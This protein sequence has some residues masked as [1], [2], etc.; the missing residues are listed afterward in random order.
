MPSAGK[1]GTGLT[2][3]T[4][5]LA[6]SS[7]FADVSTEMLYPVLPIFLTQ[8][9]GAS[10]SVLGLIE[11]VAQAV[12][13]ITQ[14][15]S[16][17]LS[18]RLRRRKPIALIGY[19]MAAL[20]K[21]FIGL[22][23]SWTG[24]LVARSLDRFGTGTRSAPRDALI[25]ASV[26]EKHRGKAFGLEGFGD[27]LG[28]FLGPLI[29]MALLVLWH[30][31]LRTIFLLAFLPALLAGL[32]VVFV[33]ETRVPAAGGLHPDLKPRRFTRSY[34]SYLTAVGLFGV[35]NI[36]NAFLILRTRDL[37]ASLTTTILIYAMFNLVAALASYPA[38]Y[39][40]DR[41][42]RKGVLLAAFT[43]VAAVYAGFAVTRN[44]VITGVL[45]A[46]FGVFQGAFRTLGKAIAT[47]CVPEELQ[48]SAV[49]WYTATIG[50]T[51]IV[52]GVAGGQLWTRVCP[53]ATFVLG[54]ACAAAGSLALMLL[55]PSDRRGDVASGGR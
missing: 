31:E 18:D 12:Q 2:P 19:G 53:A 9:L 40:S 50:L 47:D 52:A 34:W 39:L 35:G 32:M 1:N 26:G 4:F 20:S 17:W 54:A 49:G 11:G 37:G 14:G 13:N 38:G 45:F 5:L 28:A 25:A 46:L 36:S 22:A 7:L 41:L 27:N 3:N 23:S 16:G 44:V 43:I 15:L 33:K 24:V 42:G 6:L 55:V 10:G 30:V 29:A 48:A 21:P 8:T 51:G